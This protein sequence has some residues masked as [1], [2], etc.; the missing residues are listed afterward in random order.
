[1]K[2]AVVYY[3]FEGSCAFAARTIKGILESAPFKGKADLYEIKTVDA[4]KRT[5]FSK[6][7][8]GGSQVLMRKKPAL[9]PLEFDPAPYDLIILGTPVWAA[10]PAPAM[11]SFLDRHDLRGKK[12]ALFC[13][14]AGGKGR[15]LEKFRALVPGAVISGEIDLRG[16]VQA[17]ITGRLGDWLRNLG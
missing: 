17:D 5:G 10:S 1:M 14:H 13:C 4:K 9:A 15:A 8:W 16:P 7:L 11:V 12:T 6:Y 3:S 2:T